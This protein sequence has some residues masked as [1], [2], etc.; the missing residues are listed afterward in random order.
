M[1]FDY[2]QNRP[3]SIRRGLIVLL[4]VIQVVTVFTVLFLSRLTTESVLVDQAK[5]IL[6][7]AANESLEHTHGFVQP[8]YRATR[9][10]ADLLTQG[11]L[12]PDNREQIERYFLNLLSNNSELDGIYLATENGDF[13]FVSRNGEVAGAS[14]RSKFIEHAI[15]EKTVLL[16]WHDAALGFVSAREDPGDTYNPLSRPWYKQA[17][18]TDGAI[19]TEPYI[20]FTSKR[21]GITVATPFYHNGVLAGVVGADIELIA[22]SE[23]LSR[24][25][26]GAGGSAFI[27]N[28]DENLVALFTP[29]NTEGRQSL[30]MSKIE[31]IRDIDNPVVTQAFDQFDT[32]SK[33]SDLSGAEAVLEVNGV[34]YIAV[35]V[36]I[37]LPS[38]RRWF[39][40]IQV[41]K[42]SFLKSIQLN[43]NRN[44]LFGLG[45]L[46]ASVLVGWVLVSRTSKPVDELHSQ[47]IKDHL[48]T[49]FNRRHLSTVAVQVFKKLRTDGATLVIAM[50]DIDRFKSVNDT[51]GHGVGDEILIAFS[52]RLKSGLRETDVIARY[53]GE[54]FVVLLPETDI[55]EAQP[56]LE[57]LRRS[58][59][60][61]AF[62]TSIG[63]IDITI[64]IGLAEMNSRDS[65]WGSILERADQ[66][67][68]E[69]KIGGRNRV[70]V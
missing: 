43:Q 40:G 29:E 3:K 62:R 9:T 31:K 46:L 41:P 36:P 52:Q 19:W 24:L 28:Q 21:P 5:S 20:F 38:S 15:G 51:Y 66:N 32:Y 55:H 10:S 6:L 67:L 64:S 18:A 30:V 60:N 23:F 11:V 12:D 34:T 33:Q 69:A 17:R 16:R 49:L 61:S 50:I 53:G 70:A 27:V 58:V 7:N 47:A 56:M 42:D 63:L 59:G 22:L 65:T 54:E 57:R 25:R 39:I 1:I 44:L 13:G 68:Y 2:L 35:C 37:D 48:T 8:A 26:I 14:Y 45:V 4:V